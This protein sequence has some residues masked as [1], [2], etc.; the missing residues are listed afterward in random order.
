MIEENN[1]KI[2]TMKAQINKLNIEIDELKKPNS[3]K[4]DNSNESDDKINRI[5][6]FKDDVI[7]NINVFKKDYNQVVKLK[8]DATA[9]A[10]T[11]A[12]AAAAAAA[13]AKQV[14]I[15]QMEQHYASTNTN[16]L[17][18]K[19][20]SGETYTSG[21]NQDNELNIDSLQNEILT[22]GQSL[23]EYCVSDDG[24]TSLNKSKLMMLAAAYDYL[25]AA[26]ENGRKGHWKSHPIGLK[27]TE[28][29]VNKLVALQEESQIDSLLTSWKTAG[30]A[31]GFSFFS[32]SKT[33]TRGVFSQKARDAIDNL[34]TSHNTYQPP[35][36][37]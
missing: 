6:K 15:T 28:K 20:K 24:N 5:V 14:F 34:K 36:I 33:G 22:Q 17:F 26:I 21:S 18:D 29:L 31:P 4:T 37:P 13:D 9:K 32:L 16:T 25:E 19:L 2:E 3:A 35:I 7:I 11:E 23:V 10:E 12:A 1:S 27:E 8:A 30:K